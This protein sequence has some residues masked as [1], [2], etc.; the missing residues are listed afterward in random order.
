MLL[1]SV[2]RI[3]LECEKTCGVSERQVSQTNLRWV[4]SHLH[5]EH[6]GRDLLPMRLEIGEKQV[7]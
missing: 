2:C 4:A 3:N 1:E 7:D 5:A 6:L